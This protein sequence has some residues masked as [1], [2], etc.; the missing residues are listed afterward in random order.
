LPKRPVVFVDANAIW[1]RRIAEALAERRD[2][3]AVLPRRYFGEQPDRLLGSKSEDRQAL[4]LHPLSAMPGWASVLSAVGQLQIARCV[5]A[6]A[7][8]LDCQPV[9]V[10]T[11]P[12]YKRAAR[13]LQGHHPLIYYCA[14]DYREYKGFGGPRVAEAEAEIIRRCALS[15]FVSEA[16]RRRAVSD[17]GVQPATTLVSANA[18]EP[19]FLRDAC[20]A[21]R[22]PASPAILAG[23]RRPMVGVLGGLSDRLDLQLLLA[24]AN[25]DEVGTLAIIGSV[26]PD[27]ASRALQ[28]R[29]SDKVIITGAVPHSDMHTYAQAFD[30]AL[31]PYAHTALNYFCSPL[32]LYDHLATQV[33][34]FATDACDQINAFGKPIVVGGPQELP[35]L[36]A[37][38]LRSSALAQLGTEMSQ[39]I[40]WSCR[41]AKMLDAID[42][43]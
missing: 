36:I 32:R 38:S 3:A 34:I 9:V 35:Q 4:R 8:E 30:V 1:H 19:R 43:L 12:V 15:I 5:D 14:D 41:A 25:L 39:P 2:T 20:K 28:L 27:T 37:H 21:P 24:V 40:L 31:I 26:S 16:L 11:S 33:T 17:Y 10:L 7:S 13:L 18:T 22:I 23:R 6:I 42:A 29:E